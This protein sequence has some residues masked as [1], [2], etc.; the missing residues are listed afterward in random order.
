MQSKTCF[1]GDLFLCRT[2]TIYSQ[3][4]WLGVFGDAVQLYEA[5]W[6]TKLSFFWKALKTKLKIRF[7]LVVYALTDVC[8]HDW[9]LFQS[10]DWS[11]CLPCCRGFVGRQRDITFLTFLILAV[12]E[13]V[14]PFL[15]YAFVEW[16]FVVTNLCLCTRCCLQPPATVSCLSS[17]MPS[18]ASLRITYFHSWAPGWNVHR[19][20][21]CCCCFVAFHALNTLVCCNM[22]NNVTLFIIGYRHFTCFAKGN[23]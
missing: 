5:L 21:L 8:V 18:G 7:S 14:G 23:A 19:E 17:K 9:F 16:W 3:K 4:T 2:L 13:R 20:H 15:P 6:C 1:G 10:L 12:S 11:Y 22:L